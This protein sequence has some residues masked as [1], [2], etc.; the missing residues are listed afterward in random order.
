[1]ISLF[2]SPYLFVLID[3]VF[4]LTSC[5]I[6]DMLY[7]FLAFNKNFYPSSPGDSIRSESSHNPMKSDRNP[8][9]DP[10]D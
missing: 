6:C 8:G 4:R 1:M 10:T 5:F 7:A 2:S 3:L 9:D